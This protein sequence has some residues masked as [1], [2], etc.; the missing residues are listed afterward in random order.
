MQ[1]IEKNQELLDQADDERNEKIRDFVEENNVL[2]P[3]APIKGGADGLH[4]IGTARAFIEVIDDEPQVRVGGG[5]QTLKEYHDTNKKHFKGVIVSHMYNSNLQY[6]EVVDGLLSGQKKF[7]SV[8]VA[9]LKE[10]P[11]KNVSSGPEQGK[12]EEIKEGEEGATRHDGMVDF[13][14]DQSAQ[15]KELQGTLKFKVLKQRAPKSGGTGAEEDYDE[16]IISHLINPKLSVDFNGQNQ[17]ADCDG[18]MKDDK[19]KEIPF[20]PQTFNLDVLEGKE[21]LN[22]YVHMTVVDRDDEV[23]KLKLK[24]Q[25]LV[26]GGKL[27]N[28]EGLSKLKLILALEKE[29]INWY[30]LFT[31]EN[32]SPGSIQIQSKFIPDERWK[33]KVL[34]IDKKKGWGCCG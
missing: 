22:K 11:K 5:F 24:M 21:D 23:G 28:L 16:V 27:N 31:D 4:L 3:I 12:F 32:T 20:C 25:T 13:T 18:D 17:E 15:M 8:T 1:L 6:E 9:T 26:N 19:G 10:Q 34:N 30:P 14:K 29:H 33:A 7:Q 2:I